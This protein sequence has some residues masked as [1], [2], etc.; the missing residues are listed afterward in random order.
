MSTKAELRERLR[1]STKQLDEI[2]SFLLDPESRVVSELLDV[3]AK[4]GTPEEINA[5]AA[6]AG[7]LKNLLSRLEKEK[8]PYVNDAQWLIAQKEAKAFVSVRE[9]RR[10]VLR[11]KAD[12]IK[13]P[14]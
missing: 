8:S 11:E 3:V 9:Y 14:D 5:K 6:E 12:K 1:I 13:F 7:K 10:S 2:N 4:Y